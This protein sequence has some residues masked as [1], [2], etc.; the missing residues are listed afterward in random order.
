MA[1]RVQERCEFIADLLPTA[2]LVAVVHGW[3]MVG[4]WLVYGWFMIDETD[5]RP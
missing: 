4:S 3:F 5:E 2:D 1:N